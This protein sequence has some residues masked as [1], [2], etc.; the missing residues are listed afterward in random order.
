MY[1]IIYTV[2]LTATLIFLMWKKEEEESIFPLKII[3]Y[4]LLGSFAFNFD[5]LSIPLGFIVYLLFFRPKL[6]VKVKR[7][8]AIIG[9]VS[10]VIGHW[11][12]P[13]VVQHW[14][15]RP[16]NI[17]HTLG[18]VYELNF[19]E[20][21]ELVK[22]ELDLESQ[23]VMLENFNVDYLQDGEV[24]GMDW[25][26]IGHD[27]TSYQ[28]YQ[29]RYEIGK[30]RYQV[31]QSKVQSWLQYDR[32]IEAGNF[33]EHL[34]VLD[35]K[36]LTKEKG[37]YHSYVIQSSGERMNVD[38]E[39]EG[40]KYFLS[41]EGIEVLEDKWLP[42]EGNHIIAYAMKKTSEQKDQNGNVTQESFEGVESSIYLFDVSYG[43]D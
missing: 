35:V 7:M 29:V 18:S 21:F 38:V 4:Y 37:D 40:E 34:N 42:A 6:N 32:L 31:T 30:D 28:L 14:E 43:E 27:G 16:I 1:S 19:Q 11:I 20:E 25:Q 24:T 33:F 8:A 15:S 36:E 41:N 2:L 26:L 39:S 13:S 17:E 10:F 22:D 3:G 23:L 12:T 5:E 9:V